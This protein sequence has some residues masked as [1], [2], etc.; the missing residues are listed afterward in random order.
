MKMSI[1]VPSLLLALVVTVSFRTVACYSNGKVTDACRS[2]EP[3][4]GH[5]SSTKPHTYTITV[6]K[7]IFSPGDQV[8]VTLSASKSGTTYF[9][10]FLIEA[11]DAANLDGGAVGSFTLVNITKSQLLK[12]GHTQESAVSHT[13]DSKKRQIQVTWNSP[14]SVP[15][16]IQFLVTVVHKYDVYWVRI[17]GPVVSQAGVTPGPHNTATTTA[18]TVLPRPFSSE[19]C[20]TR[21]SCLRDPVGCDPE[22]EPICFFLS[23]TTVGQS[24]L[25][26]LSG[27]ADG[28]ISFALSLDKWMGNDDMYLCVRDGNRVDIDAANVVGRTHPVLASQSFL[29][30]TAW[31]LSDGVIQCS[32]RRDVH[33]PQDL[34]RFSL[35]E[36]YYLFLANGRAENGMIHRHGRQ[37]LI[38]TFQTVI[39]GAPQNLSGSRSPLLMKFHGAF[40]LIAWM[41]T[42]N[43]GIIIARYFKDVWPDR[44]LCGLGGWFQ[45]HR[46]LMVLTVL[47]TSV[48]FTLPFIYRG[49]WSHS[50]GAHPYLGCTV[51]A[52][53]GIQPVMAAFRPPPGSARRYIFNWMHYCAGTIAQIIAVVAIFLGIHQQ[54]LHLPGPWSTGIL[55]GFVVWG[56]VAELIL[57]FHSRCSFKCERSDSEDKEI[58]LESTQLTS[59]EGSVFKKVVLAVFLCGN[60][61]LL[62]GLLYSISS[63]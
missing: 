60:A 29:T 22:L 59:S 20:G 46:A 56:V 58:L 36:S 7:S 3:N 43:T 13:S 57:E 4:H 32:F 39:T 55:A 26:E 21:K 33:I 54:A 41:T 16:S 63:V 49:G 5:H 11:R 23:F 19:G 25:F 35:N 18:P 31:R 17:P 10:G 24:T 12:C 47:L 6:D 2:M 38:S 15:P 27:T 9:K 44:A 52:L 45:V 61:S 34:T 40:M 1:N 28:Y 14:E 30:D 48:A 62:S 50:A 37:P 42:V 51:M 53:A 8:Q